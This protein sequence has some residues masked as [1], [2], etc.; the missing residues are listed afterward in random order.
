[1]REGGLHTG[2]SYHVHWAVGMAIRRAGGDFELWWNYTLDN[3]AQ[4]GWG[5]RPKQQKMGQMQEAWDKCSPDGPGKEWLLRCPQLSCPQFEEAAVQMEEEARDDAAL[6]AATMIQTETE[7]GA[8]GE[9]PLCA[10]PCTRNPTHTIV[11]GSA[12][13]P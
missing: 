2:L 9:W 10:C 5:G 3:A 7:L 8:G 12:H 6:L 11:S 4:H 1:M 13:P